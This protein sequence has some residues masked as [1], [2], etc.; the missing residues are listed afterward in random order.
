MLDRVWA[1]EKREH[2]P[3][4]GAEY[5]WGW[6][7]QALDGNGRRP[8]IGNLAGIKCGLEIQLRTSRA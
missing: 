3:E 7:R 4:L 8:Q 6:G 2:N 1:L 5:G